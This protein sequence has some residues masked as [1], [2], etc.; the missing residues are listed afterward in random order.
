[1]DTDSN[2]EYNPIDKSFSSISSISNLC[3][4]T[5]E[6]N[7]DLQEQLDLHNRVFKK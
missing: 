3:D 4:Q 2:P 5:Q 6:F 1:M 7:E